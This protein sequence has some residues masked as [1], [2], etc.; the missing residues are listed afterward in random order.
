MATG[1]L[2]CLGGSQHLKSK[3]GGGYS[4]ELNCDEAHAATLPAAFAALFPGAELSE[5]HA[6]K[7]K[8]ELPPSSATLA[9]IFET[10]EANKEKLG[11]LNY[12]ASQPTLETIFLAIC[13][14]A[15]ARAPA[16]PPA[17]GA[18]RAAAVTPAAS[19][20]VAVAT[21]SVGAVAGAAKPL[22]SC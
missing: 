20:P 10:M 4:I 18:A 21:A 19:P 3:Y 15:A 8:Y 13:G 2:Q 12:A 7:Y 6:G 9:Q 1:R 5:H 16:S 11:V 17:G 22:H 14:K